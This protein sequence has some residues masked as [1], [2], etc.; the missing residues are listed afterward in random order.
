MLLMPA[1]VNASEVLCSGTVVTEARTAECLVLVTSFPIL[2]EVSNA[3]PDLVGT[4]NVHL[5]PLSGTDILVLE[6]EFKS[7]VALDF[8]DIACTLSVLHMPWLLEVGLSGSSYD[9][10]FHGTGTG[11]P[12]LSAKCPLHEEIVCEAKLGSGEE[13]YAFELTQGVGEPVVSFGESEVGSCTN[14]ERGD[15]GGRAELPASVE[16]LA[17]SLS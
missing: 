7:M 11:T 1:R 17:G 10:V 8:G 5:E 4:A 15:A 12:A 9:A 2:F 6:V 13:D 14:G 16:G 3:H